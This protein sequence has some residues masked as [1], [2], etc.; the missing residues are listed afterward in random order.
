MKDIF[1]VGFKAAENLVNHDGVEHAGYMSFLT[2]LSLFPFMVFIMAVTGFIGNSILGSEILNAI[3]RTL[4]ADLTQALLPRINEIRS[5]PPSSLLTISIIGTIWTA[6]SSFEG[7]RTILN[8]V[9]NVGSLPSYFFRRI[10]SI[11]EFLIISIVL[12]V[13]TAVLIW[14]PY[15]LDIL[16]SI[17]GGNAAL[18]SLFAKIHTIEYYL[19][20]FFRGIFIFIILFLSVSFVYYQIPN[21]KM[22]FSQQ[23]P[24]T[25]LV[26]ISWYLCA[27]CL[28]LY[29]TYFNQVNV[30]YGSLVGIIAALLFFFFIHMILIWGAEFNYLLSCKEQKNDEP[31]D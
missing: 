2:I 16:Q 19:N 7:L 5:G 30:I 31:V 4:P 6:S 15:L 25:V 14:L 18:D 24:G 10:R 22:K 13:G 12:I 27:Q 21:T 1:I 26:V 8:R 28:R 20:G 3:E 11:F 9:Y 23:I 17:I 29:F